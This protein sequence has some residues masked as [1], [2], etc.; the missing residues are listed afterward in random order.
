MCSER[1]APV[2]DNED[3]WAIEGVVYVDGSR[4][5]GST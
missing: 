4:V 1:V 5:A 3:A 2:V